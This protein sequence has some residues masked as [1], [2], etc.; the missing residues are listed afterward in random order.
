MSRFLIVTV[1][2]ILLCGCG[3]ER[4]WWANPTQHLYQAGAI[5]LGADVISLA[6]TDKTVDDHI[7]GIATDE[8]CSTLRASHGGAW[9]IP[10]P[11]PTPMIDRTS[12][13]YRSLASATCLTQPDPYNEAMFVGTRVD[14]VPAP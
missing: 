10:N 3:V 6:A 4:A 11:P 7:I 9:C 12:Y 14:R 13:C 2:S 5:F 8:D 1:C